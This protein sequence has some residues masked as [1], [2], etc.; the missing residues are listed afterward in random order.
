MGDDWHKTEEEKYNYA[1]LY[2]PCCPLYGAEKWEAWKQSFSEDAKKEKI[3]D[4]GCGPGFTVQA[5]LKDGYDIVGIDIASVPAES[6]W[7]A[8]GVDRHCFVAPLDA[9]P[10]EDNEFGIVVCFGVMEHIP[11]E[12]I[13]PSLLEIKRVLRPK[14]L[15]CMFIGLNPYPAKINGVEAHITLKPR[16][17]WIERFAEAGF[18]VMETPKLAVPH[19]LSLVGS[20]E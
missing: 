15:V 12:G 5:A 9:I 1:Y 14:G 3:L 16:E 18:S 13:M 17:W 20:Y 6:I 19:N 11:E 4:A 7:P 8:F 2:E 10:F